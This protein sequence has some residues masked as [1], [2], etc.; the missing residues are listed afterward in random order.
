MDGGDDFKAVI[1]KVYTVRKQIIHG[2]FR[3]LIKAQL[4]KL[5]RVKE[6]SLIDPLRPR[7]T[8]VAVP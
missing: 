8:V 6:N 2:D 7:L 3:D 4:I 5:G 1:G